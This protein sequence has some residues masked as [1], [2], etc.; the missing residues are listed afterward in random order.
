[1]QVASAIAQESG[2]GIRI[3]DVI[4]RSPQWLRQLGFFPRPLTIPA[5]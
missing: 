5:T 4:G 1:M 2:A 3:A